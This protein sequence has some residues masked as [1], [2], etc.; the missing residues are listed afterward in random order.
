LHQTCAEFGLTADG[1]DAEESGEE[2]ELDNCETPSLSEADD[3]E[4]SEDSAAEEE[5][6]EGDGAEEVKSS[7]GKTQQNT[8]QVP[9]H[10][11]P[12][13]LTAE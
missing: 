6:G 5:E 10:E 4:D 1:T 3:N 8:L 11:V 12:I 2:V 13:S 7:P 9:P